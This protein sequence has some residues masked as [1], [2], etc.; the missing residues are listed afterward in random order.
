MRKILIIISLLAITFQVYA[1]QEPSRIEKKSFPDVKEIRFEQEYGN[2]TVTEADSEQV[3]LEIHYFD[4]GDLKPSSDISTVNNILEIKTVRPEPRPVRKRKFIIVTS[5][6]Y[7]FT[8]IDYI[9]S[10]P[11][12]VAMKVN[13]KYGNVTMGDFHGSFT[14]DFAFGKLNAGSFFKSP[15]K[16][17]SKYTNIEMNEVDSLDLSVSFGNVNINRVNTLDVQSK[18]TNY[19]IDNIGTVKA[20]FSFGNINIGSVADIDAELHY[21]PTNI[22]NLG[23]KLNLKC[24]QSNV[25]IDNSSKHLESVKFNGSYSN[26]KLE[27]DRDLSANLDVNLKYGNLSIDDDYTVKYSFSEKDLTS[28]IKKGVIGNGTP[29]ADINISTSF[30]NVSIK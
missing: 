24:S 13:I 7:S 15:V 9:V 28:F 12:N 18:Y 2:I 23:K 17:S 21:A 20:N 10:V 29:T 1:Q 8:K 25:K 4:D 16:I 5:T 22:D 11:K 14:G 27:I 19:N 30:A 3:E 6:Y 26:F